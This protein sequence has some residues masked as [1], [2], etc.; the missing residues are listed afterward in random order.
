MRFFVVGI[1]LAVLTFPALFQTSKPNPKPPVVKPR[2][3]ADPKDKAVATKP[4]TAATPQKKPVAAKPDA[5][6]QKAREKA[7]W[8]NALSIADR[9]ESI[10]AL[11]KFVAAFPKADHLVEARGL[12]AAAEVEAGNEKIAAG[13]IDA[14]V[15]LYKAAAQGVPAPVVQ[16]FWDEGLLAIPGNLYFRGR[17]EAALEIVGLLEGKAGTNS[18]Q[19][20]SLANFFLT[21]ED[22]ATARRLATKVID[23]EPAS[24]AAY[25]TLGLADRMDFQLEDSEAR[26]QKALDLEPDSAESKRGLAEMKRS[27]GKAGEATA[28]YRSIL[29]KNPADIAAKTGLVLS[30]FEDDKR[31]DAEAEMAQALEAAPGN[32]ILLAGAAY[33]YAA[34]NDG[35]KAVDLS[36]KAIAQSPRFIWSYI[37]LARGL[38]LQG[39]AA[40]AEQTLLSARRYGNFPTLRYELASMRFANGYYREAAEELSST[41]TIKDGEISTLLGGRVARGS[42]SFTELVAYERRASIFAPTAADDPDTAAKLA[43]LLDLEG[44]LNAAA[45]NADAV[46]KAADQFVSGTDKM[47]FYRQLYAA[48][49][50]LDK[51]IALPKVIELTRAAVPNADLAL[52]APNSSAA[53]L[54][55]ELYESRRIA[56]TRGE[57][58]NVP[59]VPRATLSAVVRG[60]IEDINGWAQYQMGAGDEA[61]VRLKRAVGVLPVDSAWWRSSMWRLGSALVLTGKEAEG[62]D[63]YIKAYKRA[64]PDGIHY[65]VIESLYRKINGSTDGLAEKVGENPLGAVAENIQPQLTPEPTIRPTPVPTPDIRGVPIATPKP[66]PIPTPEITP[67]PEPSPR[68]VATP[69]PVVNLTPEASPTPSKPT[70][71][72]SPDATPEPTPDPANSGTPAASQTPSPSPETTPVPAEQRTK[73]LFPPVIITIPSPSRTTRDRGST[74]SPTPTPSPS[75]AQEASPVPPCTLTLSEETITLRIGGG[76]LAVIVSRDDDADIDDI[77]AISSSPADVSLR[78][79]AIPGVRSRALYVLRAIGKKPGV[80]QVNF[81]VPCARRTITVRVR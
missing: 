49:A 48:T 12:I 27:L 60:R 47:Q 73:D 44:E 2:V 18:A 35:E 38:L 23:A 28:L 61:V 31:A 10:A 21:I 65:A 29:E 68:T 11:Q 66:S 77:E 3:T 13:D 76:D 75:P 30:L 53:V 69:E 43:A 56:A 33:W 72:P 1:L 74:T 55:G 59:D 4:K 45:P 81:S 67:T 51:K 78:R 41:F 7:Q 24:G 17:R 6:Q 50:L 25:R 46:A 22:A 63:A 71:S 39:R 57:Y 79:E 37:A 20:L 42:K 70:P 5:A 52:T 34:H 80:F 58:V 16:G 15:T 8:D 26:F 36:R 40:E 62:L 54:A 64:E 9:V 14:A 32:V 19:L